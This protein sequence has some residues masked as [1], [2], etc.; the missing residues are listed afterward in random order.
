MD[1]NE[2]F[3]LEDLCFGRDAFALFTISTNIPFDVLANWR[4]PDKTRKPG[5]SLA[6]TMSEAVAGGEGAMAGMSRPEVW[7]HFPSLGIQDHVL[8]LRQA[9]PGEATFSAGRCLEKVV[10]RLAVRLQLAWLAHRTNLRRIREGK[11]P[12]RLGA[13]VHLGQVMCGPRYD[14]PAGY[15]IGYAKRVEGASR[16]GEHTRIFVSEQARVALAPPGLN[17]PE[18]RDFDLKFGPVTEVDGKGVP[19]LKA[20]ELVGIVP[21]NIDTTLPFLLAPPMASSDCGAAIPP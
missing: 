8:L 17:A 14:R 19:N 13:G 6:E 10:D 5:R 2:S 3:G 18:P 12:F 4:C 16:R 15:S 21:T 20:S 11:S 1:A 9:S 7:D